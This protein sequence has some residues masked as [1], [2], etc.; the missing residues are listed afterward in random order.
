M[1]SVVVGLRAYVFGGGG[2][3]GC[4]SWCSSFSVVKLCCCI[5]VALL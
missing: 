2:E 1:D 5:V 3:E 4:G